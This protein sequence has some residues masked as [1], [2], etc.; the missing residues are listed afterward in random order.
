MIA[1]GDV[2]KVFFIRDNN[3]YMWRFSNQEVTVYANNVE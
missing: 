2:G 3:K 1:G